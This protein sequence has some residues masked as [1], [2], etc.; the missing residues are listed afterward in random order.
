[1]KRQFVLLMLGVSLCRPSWASP[2]T[3]SADVLAARLQS[4]EKVLVV[5]VRTPA[6][7]A[8]GHL[9]GAINLPHANITGDEEVLRQWKEQPVMLYCR[10]GRRASAAAAVLEEKGFRRLEQLQGDMPGWEKSGYPVQK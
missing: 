4:G 5:D 1:M 10:S 7:F 6:E 8:S 2:E 3:I 9:P